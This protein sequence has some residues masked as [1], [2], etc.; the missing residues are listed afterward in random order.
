MILVHYLYD[1]SSSIF[2]QLL[3]KEQRRKDEFPPAIQ[4]DMITRVHHSSVPSHPSYTLAK[5]IYSE[6]HSPIFA[7]SVSMLSKMIQQISFF[8]EW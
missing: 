8:G 6:Q 5:R 4:Q 2:K 3:I 7:I 1:P